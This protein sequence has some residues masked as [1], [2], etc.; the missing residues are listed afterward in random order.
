MKLN[1]KKLGVM[2][3]RLLPMHNGYYQSH[4]ENWQKEFELCYK[5]KFH[6]IEWIIDN[7]S[8]NSNPIR[9]RKGRSEILRYSKKYNVYVDTICA[10]ILM[11]KYFNYK[12]EFKEW[13]NL[14]RKII[15]F[16]YLL[17]VKVIVLPLI[18]KMSLRN[19]ELLIL[20]VDELIK[21]ND[22][23]EKKNIKIALEL[24]LPPVKVK[25]L[26]NQINSDFIG[27][28]Y[29]IGNSAS[30]KFDIEKEFSNYGKYIFE[31]H[32]K[33]RRINKGSCLLGTGDANFINAV[34]LIKEYKLNCPIIMQA[35]R[36]YDGLE[37]TVLQRDWFE[38]IL[39][40]DF[41]I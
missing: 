3:G 12:S 33:D 22:I 20:I 32:V 5:Y 1:N 27:I 18:E 39:N 36:D 21:A 31:I 4:P 24:D 8:Y 7:R 10:D 30:L 14:F 9:T 25:N 38:K 28:N 16:S 26:V 11:Q 15:D 34:K 29:D 13:S 2:Q 40:E 19:E 17:N 41:C 37:I 6:S 35:F 23:L